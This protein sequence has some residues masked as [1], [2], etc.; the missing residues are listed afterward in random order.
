MFKSNSS[1]IESVT[2]TPQRLGRICDSISPIVDIKSPSFT[3]E[4]MSNLSISDVYLFF[5]LY[6]IEIKTK[7]D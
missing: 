6:N 4:E 5:S 1:S 3:I 2:P 7:K